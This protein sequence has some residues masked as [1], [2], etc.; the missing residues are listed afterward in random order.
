VLLQSGS[1]R[2]QGGG[3]V[4]GPHRGGPRAHRPPGAADAAELRRQ[5]RPGT[6][7]SGYCIFLACFVRPAPLKCMHALPRSNKYLGTIN[8]VHCWHISPCYTC[9]SLHGH[10]CMFVSSPSTR[11]ALLP[12]P[13][14][15]DTT[16]LLISLSITTL[17]PSRSL[18]LISQA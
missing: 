16:G 3:A 18:N 11:V 6:P 4:R 14:T 8:L 1:R 12:S 17:L 2:A 15:V 5:R 10:A 13:Q 9:S 7:L